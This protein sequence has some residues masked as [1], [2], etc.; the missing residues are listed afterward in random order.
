MD[1][2]QRVTVIKD[3]TGNPGALGLWGFGVTTVLLSVNNTGLI[4]MS[5]VILGMAIFVGGLAQI[6]AGCQEWYKNNTF[7]AVA[8]TS[9]GAFWLTFVVILLIPE[10]SFGTSFVT[11]NKSMG[12]FLIMWGLFTLYMFIG[13]LKL[14]RM[15]QVVF[16]TLIILFF[17][18][19]ITEFTGSK[20]LALASG[21]EGI[22]CGLSACYGSA[23]IVLK[24]VYAK[25]VLPLGGK[26]DLDTAIYRNKE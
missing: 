15:L 10:T 4:T 18:L 6:I 3:T 25:T 8:F 1:T 7:G 20:Y 2:T 19:A 13:S 26:E 11:D 24:E 16:L 5:S 21:W 14:N 12:V 9:F 23:A 22:I 17:M